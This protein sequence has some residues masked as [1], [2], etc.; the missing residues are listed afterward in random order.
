MQEFL[1][2]ATFA[3][4]AK[5]KLKLSFLDFDEHEIE[6]N[7]IYEKSVQLASWMIRR[8]WTMKSAAIIARVFRCEFLYGEDTL[9]TPF[10]NTVRTSV[11]N[12]TIF[13]K[14]LIV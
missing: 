1:K 10:F 9:L 7:Y 11:Q 12:L 13:L 8:K 14:F 2:T 3:R 5:T 4:K 6:W